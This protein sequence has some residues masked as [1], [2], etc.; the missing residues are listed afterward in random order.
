MNHAY[1]SPTVDEKVVV[2]Q[3][4]DSSKHHAKWNPDTIPYTVHYHPEAVQCE[5]KYRHRV[6]MDGYEHQTNQSGAALC[7]RTSSLRKPRTLLPWR[8]TSVRSTTL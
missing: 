3:S 2:K 6:F 4:K 1:I 5:A 7:R 8:C